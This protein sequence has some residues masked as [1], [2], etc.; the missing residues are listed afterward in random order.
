MERFI[1]REPKTVQHAAYT[2]EIKRAYLREFD[3]FLDYVYGAI[4]MSSTCPTAARLF[5]EIA[6]VTLAH[7]E[8]LGQILHLFGEDAALNTRILQSSKRGAEVTSM[9]DTAIGDEG[10]AVH[11]YK[12]L[13]ALAP[14]DAARHALGEISAEKEGHVAAL[15]GLK[16]RLSRT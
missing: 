15:S 1:K 8:Q 13:S 12:K 11:Y 6:R 5:D 3:R 2:R 9:L 10:D 7:C 14:V 4:C 16:T